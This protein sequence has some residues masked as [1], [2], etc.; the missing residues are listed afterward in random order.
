M[1]IC[2][3]MSCKRCGGENKI[4]ST[5][6][7]PDETKNG[8]PAWSTEDLFNSSRLPVHRRSS[9]SRKNGVSASQ[10]GLRQ[11]WQ[12]LEYIPIWST[13]SVK[14]HRTVV[15][16]LQP[17]EGPI[18]HKN[19]WYV[20]R[21]NRTTETGKLLELWPIESFPRMSGNWRKWRFA[22]NANLPVRDCVLMSYCAVMMVTPRTK[23]SFPVPPSLS[24]TIDTIGAIFTCKGL[25]YIPAASI[26]MHASRSNASQIASKEIRLYEQGC[27]DSIK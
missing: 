1:E 23:D 16:E 21:V 3:H 18:P 20:N 22:W 15:L 6:L 13:R 19:E 9:K 7:F 25:Q 27:L 10:K 12:R 17:H 24:E 2:C 8:L 4:E 26:C 5:C 14:A 11:S